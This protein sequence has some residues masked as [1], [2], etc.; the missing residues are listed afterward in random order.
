MA[1]WV[2]MSMAGVI[3]VR[4]E[5]KNKS[6]LIFPFGGWKNLKIHAKNREW[7]TSPSST[8]A[9]P[10]ISCPKINIFKCCRQP[11]RRQYVPTISEEV[12]NQLKTEIKSLKTDKQNLQKTIQR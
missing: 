12:S 7:K 5:K 3:C 4:L 1:A 6:D 11:K 9:V 10:S 2:F 8:C